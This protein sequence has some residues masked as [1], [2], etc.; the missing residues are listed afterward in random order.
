[1]SKDIFKR[2]AFIGLVSKT[3]IFGLA[4]SPLSSLAIDTEHN[5]RDADHVFLTKPYLQNPGPDSITIMWITAKNSYSWVEY[6]TEVGDLVKAH[7]VTDGMVDANNQIHK[8]TL[9]ELTPGTKY[10]YIVF[11]KEIVYH[12]PNKLSYGTT[13]SS[14]KFEFTTPDLKANNMAML[15]MNDIHDRPA[16]I[17]HLMALNGSDPFEFVFF[18]G[19]MFNFQK[20]Q[21]QII[22]NMLNPCTDTFASIKPFM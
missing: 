17:P 16:S 15:I 22:H 8:I 20:D 2:R 13:I 4:T 19:D 12:Q 7:A 5:K 21:Q 6:Q 1:M 3:T 9:Q 10:S 14:K 11:S 18:N